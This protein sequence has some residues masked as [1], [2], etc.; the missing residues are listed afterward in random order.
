MQ[1][2]VKEERKKFTGSL[3]HC[4]YRYFRLRAKSLRLGTIKEQTISIARAIFS[5]SFLFSFYCY[6]HDSRSSSIDSR[7]QWRTQKKKGERDGGLQLFKW[8]HGPRLASSRLSFR[9]TPLF[10]SHYTAIVTHHYRACDE[11]VSFV[12]SLPYGLLSPHPK[13]YLL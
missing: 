5:F 2:A 4:S 6:Q 1:E 7:L 3:I 8:C 13:L 10:L 11:H 12:P 9:G